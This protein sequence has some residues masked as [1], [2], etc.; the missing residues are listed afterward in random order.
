MSENWKPQEG[1]VVEGKFRLVQK[2]GES[3]HS[4]VF[5]TE[6]AEEPKKAVIK[7]LPA[8]NTENQILRWKLD[9]KLPHPHLLRIFES[10]KCE[11]NGR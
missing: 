1:Q 11:L 6:R 4:V 7:L 10:G 5:L 3:D 8:A 2:L 9:T